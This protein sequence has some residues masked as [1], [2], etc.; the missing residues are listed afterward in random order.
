MSLHKMCSMLGLVSVLASG[1]GGEPATSDRDA[2]QQAAR[3]EGWSNT[4]YN[5]LFS[6]TLD[7]QTVT[8]LYYAGGMWFVSTS[9]SLTY[10]Q[11][12]SIAYNGQVIDP[13]N[14]T[15]GQGTFQVIGA[16]SEDAG[17][18]LVLTVAAPLAGTLRITSASVATDGS[19]GRYSTEWLPASADDP[20]AAVGLCPREVLVAGSSKTAT[21]TQVVYETMIPIGGVRWNL[22]GSK[23]SDANAIT[24][25]CSHDAIGGCVEWGYGPWGTR[26][27]E[28][29]A[30]VH[31]ACTRMKRDDVCG[32]GS[33]LT[34][35]YDAAQ[36]V[37]TIHVTDRVGIHPDTNQTYATMEA[38]WGENGASCFNETEY[39]STNTVLLS[40]LAI[41]KAQCPSRFVACNSSHQR[42]L[43]SARPC[44]LTNA[45]GD[46]VAN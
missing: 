6:A 12:S 20:L 37:T 25:G 36:G 43:L 24:L 3:G 2:V 28:S 41:I 15:T 16:D 19:F 40:R 13:R 34:T 44:T 29:M 21:Q 27:G 1:C 45:A 26:A 33:P 32:T 31:Q 17:V 7:G 4:N 11:V 46:C 8:G 38:F 18:E 22:N 30:S 35:G 14:L 39:R 9:S 10:A 23:T 5:Q 42:V